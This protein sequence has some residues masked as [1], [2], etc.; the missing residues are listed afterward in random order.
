MLIIATIF[1][2]AAMPC[3]MLP[4]IL[5][6]ATLFDI[7]ADVSFLIR[8]FTII[9]YAA[10]CRHAIDYFSLSPLMPLPPGHAAIA[11]LLLICYYAA[12]TISMML[13]AALIDFRADAC[14]LFFLSPPML[15]PLPA[16]AIS[17]MMLISSPCFFAFATTPASAAAA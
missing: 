15:L 2:I 3:F 11:M 1:I 9:D 4:L 17:L 5:C 16:Y 8:R 14:C 10:A 13:P 6:S 7:A 12:A